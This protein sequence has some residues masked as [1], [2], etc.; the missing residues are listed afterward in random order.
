MK[1]EA[2]KRLLDFSIHLHGTENRR[3]NI[4]LTINNFI[5]TIQYRD[6]IENKLVQIGWNKT[7][8][9]LNKIDYGILRRTLFDIQKIFIEKDPKEEKTIEL[10]NYIKV[11]NWNGMLT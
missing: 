10:Y 3:D 7:E 9:R 2:Y 1:N 8:K 4:D 5:E 11:N 6:E